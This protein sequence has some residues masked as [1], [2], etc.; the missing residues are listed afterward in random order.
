MPHIS[1]HG[2]EIFYQT[3]GKRREGQAPVLLIHGSTQT[4]YSCWNKVAPLLAEDYLVIVPDCRG[5]GQSSNPNMSYSF[6]EHAADMAVLI[7]ALGFERAHVIGHSNGGNIAL[8]TL[9]EHPDVIQTC[10]PQAAN[11]WVSPDLLVKEP[12]LFEPD[13]IEKNHPLWKEEMEILHAPLGK[14]YWRKLVKM[15]VDE[16]IREPNYAPEDLAQVARPTLV[17]QG[18]TDRVN[19]E[20][21]HGQFIARHIPAAELWIP[22]GIGH[23]VHDDILD[24]WIRRV[25]DFLSRRGTDAGEALYRHRLTHHPD[26]RKGVFDPRLSADNILSGTV[27][28]E[29]MQAEVLSLLKTPPA[30][31]KL[32]VLITKETPWA[33]L[34]R[35]IE[36]L[37]RK[38][39]ILAERV[40]QVR[41]GEAARVIETRGDWSYIRLEHDSYS[42]WVHSNSLHVCSQSEVKAYQSGCNAIVSASLAETWNE[43]GKLVHKIPFATLIRVTE[44]KDALASIQLPDGRMW[45]TPKADVLPLEKRPKTDEQGIAQTLEYIKRFVGVPYLWGGRSPYGFD[46][47]G[48][49]GTFY[50]FMGVNI[51][52]DADQQFEAGEVV[53]Q[54]APGDLLFF[55]EEDEDDG[56]VHISHVGISLGGDLFIHSNGTDWGTAYNSFDPRGKLYRKWL[57]ENYR[58][59]RRFR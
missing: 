44:E 38:P 53:P 21:K 24:E 11:A 1:I 54:P 41:M 3:Y 51:P 40:S 22:K 35:P 31:N 43:E 46:C 48:L 17:I 59:A 20:N 8:V 26:S 27:L 29:E 13:N 57:H 5:H 42:G 52:R 15:T 18:E 19:A 10:V 55:G 30:E 16:I 56:E 12:P 6:K 14:D 39:S 37:R 36:D 23:N 7:R 25:T 9:L 45:K 28:S 49:A 32:N 34:N 33:L 47:S 4:G 58:G 2:A 50:A